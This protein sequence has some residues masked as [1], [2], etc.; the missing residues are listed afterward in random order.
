MLGFIFCE[1]WRKIM[2]KSCVPI[3]AIAFAMLFVQCGSKKG[4]GSGN[5]PRFQSGENTIIEFSFLAT[6]NPAL[7]PQSDIVGTISDNSILITVPHGT[8]VTALVANFVTNS[9]EVTVNGVRQISGKTP[10]DFSVPVV[11][12]VAAENGDIREYSVAVTKA[13]SSEK[14]FASFSINGTEGSIDEANGIITLSLP[15]KTSLTSLAATFSA[16]AKSVKV[17]GI[18]QVSG[19]TLNDFSSDVE[20][21]LTAEDGTG[22]TYLVKSS[23]QPAPWNEI[24][25]FSF[26]KADNPSLAID[27][28]GVVSDGTISVELPYGSSRSDLAA[29]FE[30]EGVSMQVNGVA[31]V[32][33]QTKNDFSSP[34]VYQ[35]TAESGAVREYE[36]RVTVAKN[37]AK[38]ITRYYLSG[39]KGTIDEGSKTITVNFPL[40]KSLS[41]L[42]AEF[43]TTGVSVKVGETEQISGT[44]PNDFTQPVKYVV[45][46]ENGSASEYTVQAVRKEEI[47]GLW[48]FETSPEGYTVVGAQQVS[49]ITGTALLFNGTSD[50]VIVP[51]SDSLTLAEGGTIEATV[52]A[53]THR[54]Y[55]GVV[56]KGVLTDFSDETYSLQFWGSDGTLRF[57]I[58]N[59]K[60]EYL[61]V[62]SAQ[63]LATNRWYHL[64]ATWDLTGIKLYINGQLEVSAPNTIGKVRDSGGAL[65]IGAQLDKTFSS[66][67]GNIGFNGVIDRVAVYNR[68]YSDAEVQALFND[69]QTQ[70]GG[71]FTAFLLSAAVRNIRLIGVLAVVIALLFAGVYF[72]NKRRSAMTS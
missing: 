47:T 8:N 16:L 53:I 51:D 62:D 37:S 21:Q 69:Q 59:D 2:K 17:K 12:K 11:Y 36:V 29:H 20:Y 10:N 65:I 19:V 18:D 9:T 60:G 24:T 71:A 3:I 39:E 23:V 54:P 48:N 33:G 28:S 38:E 46:A 61:Y 30:T 5:Y 44:T 32:S 66:T 4:S 68:A 67:Y 45:A 70:S 49:G 58:F 13:P 15:P 14:R 7:Q 1:E 35:V 31:Q 34:L 56:H 43:I 26:R 41:G 40:S 22:R 25:G 55:A 52:M 64:T 72:Y 57:S 27:V 63:K 50:Y 6:N 42:V